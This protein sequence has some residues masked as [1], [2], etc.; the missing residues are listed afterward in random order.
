MR[1]V[2][3]VTCLRPP[4]AAASRRRLSFR[5]GVSPDF[6][7]H[8]ASARRRS[9]NTKRAQ[10]GVD[11]G[12][13]AASRARDARGHERVCPLLA[14]REPERAQQY[15]RLCEMRR[16]RGVREL[17]AGYRMGPWNSGGKTRRGTKSKSEVSIVLRAFSDPE[18]TCSGTSEGASRML[19]GGVV[20]DA[21]SRHPMG[22]P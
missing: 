18:H 21:P 7:K 20:A 4:R 6:V 14:H 3:V 8:P 1:R 22:R 2:A 13:T 16:E 5:A 12:Q 17:Y 11:R 10:R 19:S 9:A 15:R